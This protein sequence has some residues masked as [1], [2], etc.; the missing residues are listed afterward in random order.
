MD[1][2]IFASLKLMEKTMRTNRLKDRRY[3][4]V[5]LMMLFSGLLPRGWAQSGF[6]ALHGNSDGISYTLGQPF[7]RQYSI[8][9]R[10]SEGVEQGYLLQDTV[11]DD[12]CAGVGYDNFGIVYGDT[13]EEGLYVARKYVPHAREG[14]DSVFVHRLWVY[15]RSVTYDTLLLSESDLGGHIAGASVDSLYSSHG[16]DSVIFR[17]VYAIACPSDYLTTAP[18]G[19]AAVP[20]PAEGV[21]VTP[22]V[23]GLS[24]ASDAP[25]LLVVGTSGQVSWLLVA[26]GD[27][28]H[29]VQ[30]VR[31]DFPPCGDGFTAVDGDGNVYETVRVGV[32]CW[33]R[34]NVYSRH[35]AGSG[36]EIPVA[37]IYRAPQFPD[38]V[39]TL[40]RYG[41]L[42]S[43]YS[44]MGIEENSSFP[45]SANAEGE[46]QGVCPEGWHIPTTAEM[47]ALQLYDGAALKATDGLWI[48]EAPND[49]SR[50]SIVPGGLHNAALNRNEY[51]RAYAYLWSADNDAQTVATA[52][53]LPYLCGDFEFT[54]LNK[55]NGCS[56][57]C[58]KD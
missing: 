3:Y 56:V 24:V 58:A 20:F 48:G 49:A 8:E 10:V 12:A 23:E 38:T 25:P 15:P 43:W 2:G 9:I 32:D 5:I 40:Q 18:Y 4:V 53:Y 14:Y 31:A 42:Y 46:V 44:A 39:E 16:C 54:S 50:F 34:E 33:M 6:S 57:R 26:G 35:Y 29:C 45:P 17:M 1:G 27:T 30:N 7:Y 47:S 36:D 13:L 41:R 52:G 28:F 21:S 55:S 19:V 11:V 22:S 51:L 37:D